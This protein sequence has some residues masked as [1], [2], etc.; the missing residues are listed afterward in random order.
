MISLQIEEP[1]RITTRLFFKS[2]HHSTSKSNC[3]KKW[4]IKYLKSNQK[5]KNN[6]LYTEFKK[7][8]NTTYLSSDSVQVTRQLRNILRYKKKCVSKEFYTQWN[9]LSKLK[10]KEIIFFRKTKAKR[11]H[12]QQTS[13][14]KKCWSTSAEGNNRWNS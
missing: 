3:W 8:R 10:M 2:L 1:Q 7:I 9:Y 6:K 4:K 11:I 5:R 13:T 14:L 12:Y